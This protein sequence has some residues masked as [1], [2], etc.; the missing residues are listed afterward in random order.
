MNKVMD[1]F[2][3][4]KMSNLS[5]TIVSVFLSLIHSLLSLDDGYSLNCWTAS[6]CELMALGHELE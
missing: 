2:G 6:N 1:R 3:K 5:G 4:S